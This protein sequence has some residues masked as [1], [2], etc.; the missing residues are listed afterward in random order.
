MHNGTDYVKN[1]SFSI[2]LTLLSMTLLHNVSDIYLRKEE[3]IDEKLLEAF[4][5]KVREVNY[6]SSNS[7]K[8]EKYS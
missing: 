3:Q 8:S 1:E 7:K 4:L 6:F 2:G 5:G